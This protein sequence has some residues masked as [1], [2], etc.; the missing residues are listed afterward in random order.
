MEFSSNALAAIQIGWIV[1][2]LWRFF[3]RS[4]EIPL[5][6]SLL[7][8]YFGSYRYLAVGMGWSQWADISNLGFGQ[9]TSEDALTAL[10]AMVLGE[11]IFLATYLTF[12][13][14][15]FLPVRFSLAPAFARQFYSQAFTAALVLLPTS[16]LVNQIVWGMRVSG[17]S[18]AFG[19]SAYLYLFPLVLSTLAI[20][21]VILW[22]YGNLPSG[23]RLLALVL[24]GAI[25]YTTFGVSGRF[26]FLSWLIASAVILSAS[27]SAARRLGFMV[28][29]LGV[30]L[31]VFSIA[32]AQRGEAYFT[33][34]GATEASWDRLQ[35]A[36]D[37]NMLDGMV[38]MQEVIPSRLPFRYGGEHL[39][40]FIRPIPRA[41]WPNK[42]VSGYMLRIAGMD[43]ERGATLG[44]SPSLFGSFYTE[45]GLVG[46]VVL[47]IL[48]AYCIAKLISLSLALHPMAALLV[49]CLVCAA[50]VPLLRGGDLPGIY[51]WL[52]AAFW[53]FFLLFLLKRRE[54]AKSSPW[55][56]QTPVVDPAAVVG[57][58]R[59]RG[60]GGMASPPVLTR[61]R[62]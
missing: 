52:G 8:G 20:V 59:R 23:D 25:F 10:G 9:V 57:K 53:P 16:F 61:F 21:L 34:G 31:V 54:L 37:A 2:A 62:G 45:G 4:D 40:I 55:F 42:P 7:V 56:L 33:E 60:R 28:A 48:Y 39:E 6:T 58:A 26:K 41:W 12:Q 27:Y 29:T 11:S 5:L 3:K 51:A 38:L 24:I 32:G 47:S 18:M 17:V 44:I 36:E 35:T 50:L 14:A 49:R 46:I 15:A 43:Q 30:L 1:A 19:I 22:R 13:R